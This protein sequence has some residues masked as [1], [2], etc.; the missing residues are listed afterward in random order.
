VAEYLAQRL[1]DLGIEA[2]LQDVE[3]GRANVVAR[4]RGEGRGHLVFTGHIDVVPPGGQEWSHGPFDA[5]LVDG[6]IY[7]RGSADMKGGV[8]SIVTAMAALVASGFRPKADII[9]AATYGEEAGM[10]GARAMAGRGSLEGSRYLVV[11]EP[12]NL[13]VFI[14]EKGVLWVKIRALGRTGH[15]SMPWLGINAVSYMARLIPRLE[16]YP[17]PFQASDLLGKP[18]I[19]V[20]M[21]EGGN[22]VNVVPDLC[23]ITIDLRTVPMQ[24]HDHIVEAL[25]ALANEVAREFHPDLRVEVEVQEDVGSLETDPDEPLVEA[26]IASVRSVRG[27]EPSVGGVT[28]GTD[29]AYLGPGYNIPMVICG[30][31]AQGMA[32]QPDEYVEVAQLAQ[33]AAIYADLA[34]RLLG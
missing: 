9:L 13:D 21:I 16:A 28:Y 30:P 2:T 11:A 29:A 4:I 20:N 1:R 8:A 24:N 3:D 10:L 26:M 25:E 34:R 12:S 22:K 17:F 32:H 31:G 19:S 33:A 27:E 15:G 7:G 6:R 18:T 23:E 5:D 14:G